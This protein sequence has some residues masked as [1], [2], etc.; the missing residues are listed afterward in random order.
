MAKF[1]FLSIKVVLCVTFIGMVESRSNGDVE[2]ACDSMM[3]GHANPVQTDPSPYEI[4]VNAT[5]YVVGTSIT[6]TISSS[7]GDQFKGFF[8]QARRVADDQR[9]GTF[10][11]EPEQ[12]NLCS[13]VRLPVH[14]DS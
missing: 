11:A 7:S 14:P 12:R 1:E 6:V 13:E 2:E 10:N 8:I 4:S 3:P 9:I 5:E